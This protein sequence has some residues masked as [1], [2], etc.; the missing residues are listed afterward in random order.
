MAT[1][2][3][4]VYL[5]VLCIVVS[6]SVSLAQKEKTSSMEQTVNKYMR[7][8]SSPDPEV[9]EN[10]CNGLLVLH[11]SLKPVPMYYDNFCKCVRAYKDPNGAKVDITSK[12]DF[13]PC[14]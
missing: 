12:C 1:I 11:F 9:V 8:I 5:L 3:K 4:L 7:Y 10:G 13:T 14:K 2:I 6:A